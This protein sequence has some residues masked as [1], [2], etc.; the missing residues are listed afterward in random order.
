MSD[1]FSW[2]WGIGIRPWYSPVLST[3]KKSPQSTTMNPK[4]NIYNIYNHRLP[5][6]LFS[7]FRADKKGLLRDPHLWWEDLFPGE[8]FATSNF[9]ATFCW[10]QFSL[11]P[12]NHQEIKVFQ[13]F[14]FSA[15][16]SLPLVR[17]ETKSLS[18][19]GR[20]VGFSPR[21]Y[22]V[23]YLHC[24]V[25]WN[26]ISPLWGWGN[27]RIHKPFFVYSLYS[28]EDEPIWMV[29]WNVWWS[30]PSRNAFHFACGHFSAFM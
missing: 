29:P 4:Q 20:L 25:S 21:I 17:F 1:V 3:D 30:F 5:K 9:Q 13:L 19:L 27:S 8:I 12:P 28:S 2:S 15:K 23:R 24:R 18:P 6:S 14:G 7:V 11:A 16:N 22:F 26:L 10:S